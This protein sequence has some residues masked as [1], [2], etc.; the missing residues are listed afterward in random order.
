MR[1]VPSFPLRLGLTPDIIS[2]PA[3]IVRADTVAVGTR[4][5]RASANERCCRPQAAVLE[6]GRARRSTYS[7]RDFSRGGIIKEIINMYCISQKSHE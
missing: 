5:R 6:D 3:Q 1:N 7:N 2:R 4:L